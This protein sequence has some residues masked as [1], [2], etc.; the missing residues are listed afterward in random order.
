MHN[1]IPGALWLI[2]QG[3]FLG[4]AKLYR[5]TSPIP[6][7][8]GRVC[9]QE[10]LCEGACVLSKYSLAP[11][12]GQLEVF[13]TDYQRLIENWDTSDLPPFTDK[14]VAVIGSGP[15]G[16]A[17]AEALIKRGHS[18][19]VFEAAPS[20]GGLLLYGI[21]SFKLNCISTYYNIFLNVGY[22]TQLIVTV[23]H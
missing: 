22:S 19:T 1:D 15:A 13:V 23:F 6:E 3:D 14:T 21:P 8:C 20:P 11:A 5:Q 18:V 2:S 16:L 12:L 9:P 17:V 10:R 7:I 4:A